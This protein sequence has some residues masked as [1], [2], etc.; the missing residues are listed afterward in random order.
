MFYL[1]LPSRQQRDNLLEYLRVRDI[2]AVFHYVPLHS[3]PMGCSFG[4]K[5]GDLPITEDLSGRLLR[6]PFFYEITEAEQ[7][8]VVQEIEAAVRS[9]AVRRHVAVVTDVGGDS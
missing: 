1:I 9:S 5:E 4:Y 7:M 8:R 6:L 2:H 3:S